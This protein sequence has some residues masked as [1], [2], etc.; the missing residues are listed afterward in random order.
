MDNLRQLVFGGAKL[1]Q[2]PINDKIL[3]SLN[4]ELQVIEAK[5]KSDYFLILSKLIKICNG[6]NLLRSYGRGTAANSLVNYCLDITKINPL[7]EDLIFE[8]FL[9]SSRSSQLDIDIDLPKKSKTKIIKI[10]R[11]LHPEYNIYK[12]AFI[13]Q[14]ENDYEDVYDGESHYKIHPTA[15][16]IVDRKADLHSF[17]FEGNDYYVSFDLLHDPTS[18]NR[19]DIVELEYLNKLQQIT[20]DLP[21]EHHP[22]NIPLN[23]SKVFE[24]FLNDNLQNIFQFNSPELRQILGRFKPSSIHDLSLI[25]AIFRPGLWDYIPMAIKNKTYT[26]S[27]FNWSDERLTHILQQTYGLLIYQESYLHILNIIAGM[28]MTEAEMW[29]KTMMHQQNEGKTKEFAQKLRTGCKKNS[30]LN[31]PEIEKLNA[32]IE[33]FVRLTFQKSHSLSYSIIGYWGAYYKTYFPT[34]FQTVFNKADDFQK[35]ELH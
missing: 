28:P 15:I 8:R 34:K 33:R 32:L 24:F 29:R 2:L 31:E 12:L 4:Y 17:H 30:N 21:V 14:K 10:F 20:N 23:D 1:K 27:I 26:E 18:E 35:F 22:Y 25:N 3:D 19:F 11:K 5:G 16:I 6:L 13:P 7:I 9:N